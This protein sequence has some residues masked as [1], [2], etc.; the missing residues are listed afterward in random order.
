MAN[1]TT[2]AVTVQ[3]S[4]GVAKHMNS[5]SNNTCKTNEHSQSSDGSATTVDTMVAAIETTAAAAE[6]TTLHN[7]NDDEEELVWY[8]SYGSNMNPAVF[9]E[10]RKIKCLD[11][12]V[13]KVP[14]YVLTYVPGMFPYSEPAFCSC[15][16]RSILPCEDDRPDVHGVAFLITQKQYEHM[17]LTEGGWGYQEYRNHPIWNIGHYGEE[18]IECVEVP[19]EKVSEDSDSKSICSENENE[20]LQEL[21]SPSPPKSFKAMTLVGFFGVRQRYDCHSSKRYYDIVNAGAKASGLPASYRKYLKDRHPPFERS[22]CWGAWLGM[23]I[24]LLIAFPCILLELG[25]LQLCIKWNEKKLCCKSH[26]R[27]KQ[28]KQAEASP[29]TTTTTTTTSTTKV[30]QPTA[31]RRRFQDVCRP[32]WIIIKLCFLYRTF[33]ME[34]L[35]NCLMFD[36]CA[37]PNGFRNPCGSK[38]NNSAEESQ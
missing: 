37:F 25:S 4:D 22:N 18:E 6:S 34:L 29:L 14:G 35:L 12:K 10:R 20:T 24:Y 8:F 3:L 16:K 7:T 11:H 27:Q 38:T 26:K 30:H 17:L 9:E 5:N 31:K 21:P 28:E 32:P 2:P 19:P 23:R 15:L 33:V 13:C 1:K 36:C